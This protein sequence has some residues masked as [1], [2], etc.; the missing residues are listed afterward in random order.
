[1]VWLIGPGA[2]RQA[3]TEPICRSDLIAFGIK[4]KR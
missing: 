3:T 2:K 1:V 4:L